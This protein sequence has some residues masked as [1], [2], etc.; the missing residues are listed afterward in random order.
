MNMTSSSPISGCPIMT[1]CPPCGWRKNCVPMFSF[2]FVSGVM[3]EEAAIEG[4]KQGAM[5]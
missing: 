5:E 4:L 3:G 2:V 1:A